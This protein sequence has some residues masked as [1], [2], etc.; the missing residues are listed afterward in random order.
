MLN[1]GVLLLNSTYEPLNV[2]NLKRAIRLIVTQKANELESDGK[3]VR[4]ARWTFNMPTVVRLVYYVRRP[5]QRVKFT[6]KAILAR[7]GYTCQYCGEQARDLTLDH[8]IPRIMRG[9]TV[10]N[11]VVA[12]CKRCNG[13]KGGRSL[14]ESEMKLLHV[15]REPRFLPYLKMVRKANH[16]TWDKYLF[17]DP[18]SPYLIRGELPKVK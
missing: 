16:T 2:I 5:V 9:E 14:K 12:C 18:E 7:D 6:K 15:P 10:W 3:L 17:S 8:V 11:N 4:S 13:A 1:D